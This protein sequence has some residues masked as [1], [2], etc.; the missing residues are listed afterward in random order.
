MTKA[1]PQALTNPIDVFVEFIHK[2]PEGV[3]HR[4]RTELNR[5]QQ[6]S[7]AER[8]E[9]HRAY[10]AFTRLLTDL[11]RGLIE[12]VFL[13]VSKV[14]REHDVVDRDVHFNFV[15]RVVALRIFER[16]HSCLLQRDDRF[17]AG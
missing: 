3:S 1:D 13:F 8:R 17:Y 11:E 6:D 16:H 9:E 4:L 10:P 12:V 14:R 7:S 2:F 5:V 15:N